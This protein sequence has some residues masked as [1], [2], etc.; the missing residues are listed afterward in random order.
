MLLVATIGSGSM[1]TYAQKLAEHLDV[2]KLYTDI[3]Q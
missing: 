2:P 3:Y 1:D